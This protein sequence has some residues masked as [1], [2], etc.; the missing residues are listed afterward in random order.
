M[1]PPQ[2]DP[3]MVQR[4]NLHLSATQVADMVPRRIPGLPFDYG[5]HIRMSQTTFYQISTDI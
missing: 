5:G 1:P 2:E 3:E 4:N